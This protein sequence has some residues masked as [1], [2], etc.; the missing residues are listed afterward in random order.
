MGYVR[1]G[2]ILHA[3]PDTRIQRLL[4]A[5]NMRKY[6]LNSPNQYALDFDFLKKPG[7]DP[8]AT[9][10]PA[11]RLSEKISRSYPMLSKMHNELI[12]K[13]FER[14]SHYGE[15]NLGLEISVALNCKV[16]TFVA[17]D[18][19]A[20]LFSVI[21][22]G[23]ITYLREFRGFIDIEWRD[24]KLRIIPLAF[25]E[26]DEEEMDEAA[27]FQAEASTIAGRV[28]ADYTIK[29]DFKPRLHRLLLMGFSEFTE[30]KPEQFGIG[31][32]DAKVDP[33]VEQSQTPLQ[34]LRATSLEMPGTSV[35][36]KPPPRPVEDVLHFAKKNRKIARGILWAVPLVCALAV[37]RLG[38]RNGWEN[39]FPMGLIGTLILGAIPLYFSWAFNHM[40][41]K[42][43]EFLREG[44]HSEGQI[45]KV[46]PN[47]MGAVLEVSYTAAN[48]KKYLGKAVV[49]G[50]SV[51]VLTPESAVIP[52]L[53]D[54]MKP[55]KFAILTEAGGISP[56]KAKPVG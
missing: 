1:A 2:L 23:K 14:V 52:L 20:D 37:W 43:V 18:E 8:F 12:Q 39:F 22:A 9:S 50:A 17:D 13:K 16:I 24:G 26:H 49:T 47:P 30:V 7:A 45:L 25:D 53:Y 35:L 33:Q 38:I 28:G 15:I 51:K 34:D 48:G 11:S 36:K 19:D 40:S 10:L 5:Y 32:F 46:T 29:Q 4:S 27:A 6:T 41:D 56:G 31:L 42:L 44:V 21:N 54:T 55:E 3:I